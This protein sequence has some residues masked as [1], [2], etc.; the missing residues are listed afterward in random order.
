[1]WIVCFAFVDITF[2]FIKTLIENGTLNKWIFALFALAIFV[3]GW[4]IVFISAKSLKN[5]KTAKKNSWAIGFIYFI[6]IWSV[7][8]IFDLMKYSLE[9]NILNVYY[10][11]GIGLALMFTGWACGHLEHVFLKPKRKLKK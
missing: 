11:F 1:M 3:I 8:M 5:K 4:T 2:E 9:N 7:C 6:I 10:F